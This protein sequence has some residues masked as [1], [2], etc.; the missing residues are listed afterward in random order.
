[1]IIT[2]KILG[3]Q[4]L[5]YSIWTYMV[6]RFLSLNGI[7]ALMIPFHHAA[8]YGLQ[9]MF[10]WGEGTFN[11]ERLN[12]FAYFITLLIRQLDS[13]AIPTFLFVSGYFTVFT[14]KNK[15]IWPPIIKRSMQFVW[16]FLIW[17]F[18]HFLLLRVVPK[19]ISEVLTQ[20]YYIPLLIQLYLL[21]P[22][23]N[24]LATAN[25][26]LLLLITGALQFSVM[27]LRYLNS[28]GI[29]LPYLDT[30]IELTPLWFFPARIFYFTMG[31]VIGNHFQIFKNWLSKSRYVLLLIVIISG[32]LTLVEYQLVTALSNKAW[33][34]PS[35]IGISRTVYA[36]FFNL[37]FLGFDD[38]KLPMKKQLQSL[39]GQSMGLYLMNTPVIYVVSSLIFKVAPLLWENQLAYQS[40]LIITGLFIPLW[41]MQLIRKSPFRFSYRY[42]FG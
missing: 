6:R 28:L 38:L 12:S 1:V 4:I 2:V 36:V 35:F 11:F 40:I 32:S 42:I 23:F 10:F 17:T 8:A 15:N 5:N 24:R 14:A 9:I 37:A 16:P 21:A 19:T 3:L 7:A 39:G 26:K 29:I 34:G 30:L 22:L 33:L 31:V 20:Y 13:F 18:V 41:C 25:W 27:S